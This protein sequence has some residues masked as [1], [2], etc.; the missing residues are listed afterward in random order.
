M[1]S[2]PPCGSTSV[3]A[4]RLAASRPLRGK[5]SQTAVPRPS[6]LSILMWPPDCFTNPYTK[7]LSGEERLEHLV[8]D[9]YRDACPSIGHRDR[10]VVTGFHLR[11]GAASGRA[12]GQ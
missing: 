2:R 5:Y 3:V 6:S 4:S 10:D 8:L 11:I 9:R 12:K 1:V 7:L